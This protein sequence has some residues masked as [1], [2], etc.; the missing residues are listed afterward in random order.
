MDVVGKILGNEYL[1]TA[2]VTGLG[3]LAARI[4]GDNAQKPARRVADVINVFRPIAY[5]IVSAAG[6]QDAESTLRAL[7]L[8]M[9]AQ[10]DRFGVPSEDRR[11][12]RTQIDRAVAEAMA[13][14]YR[15]HPSAAQYPPPIVKA[16]GGAR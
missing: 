4:W 8:A 10:L 2:I 3:W 7:A 15:N 13:T 1:V 14:W 5:Q 11:G 9:S 16:V 6:S 12:Q